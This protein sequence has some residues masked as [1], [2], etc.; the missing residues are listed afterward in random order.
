MKGNSSISERVGNFSVS[1]FSLS[2]EPM[3]A[4]MTTTVPGSRSRRKRKL[5]ERGTFLFIHRSPDSK[6]SGQTLLLVFFS[7]SVVLSLGP[8][9]DTIMEVT[10]LNSWRIKKGNSEDQ[11]VP[12]R[13][14]RGK[15]LGKLPIK[16]FK[17]SWSPMALISRA[18]TL[19]TELMARL[20]PRPQ[21]DS[22]VTHKWDRSE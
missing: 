1:F 19:R 5:W 4:A 3:A 14:Q 22:Q 13:S 20:L 11:K 2:G 15:G 8:R 6:R 21:T 7:L 18:K 10:S 12:R 9:P 16:L 17:T